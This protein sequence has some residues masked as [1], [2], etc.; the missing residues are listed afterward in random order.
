MVRSDETRLL[1]GKD[2]FYE[3]ILGLKFKI[4][5]LLL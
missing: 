4:T 3:E 1:Y 5:G 2:Y